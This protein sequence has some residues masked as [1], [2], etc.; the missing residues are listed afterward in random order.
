MNKGN[1]ILSTTEKCRKTKL[2]KKSVEELIS[3]ILRK[4][5]TERKLSN[6]VNNY[7]KLQSLNEKR[8][9]TLKE[10]ITNYE[11]LVADQDSAINKDAD[12]LIR[13]NGIIDYKDK[14]IAENNGRITYL[15]DE[16]IKRNKTIRNLLLLCVGL[17]MV[18]VLQ[19]FM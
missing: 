4:D 13:L 18:I 15:N 2:S 14:T 6:Q 10:T 8:F 7:K 3:I 5:D 17:T 11:K 19:I 12:T 9:T 16:I 1:E